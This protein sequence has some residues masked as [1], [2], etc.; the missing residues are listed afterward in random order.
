LSLAQQVKIKGRVV[1]NSNNEP[2]EYVTVYLNSTTFG[3]VTNQS[4]EFNISAPP[5]EYEIV[6]SYLGYTPIIHQVKAEGELPPFLFKLSASEELLNE[7]K[8]EAKR[9]ISWYQNLKVFKDSFL[10]TSKNAQRCKLLNPEVLIIDFDPATGVLKVKARDLLKIENPELGYRINYLL[11]DYKYS[12][13]EHYLAYSGYPNFEEM[14]AGRAKMKKYERKRLKAYNGS[15]MHFVRSLRA[16]KLE[17]EGF[18]LRRL[19]RKP[20][21]NRPGEEEIRRAREIIQA[22]GSDFILKED[23]PLAIT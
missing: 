15:V 9:D 3:A 18:V 22:K 16:Q 17:E 10:G 5:G 1:D 7:V 20:N 6:V 21:P 14:Q 11:A 23:D 13:F 12:M 4:G 2:L 8:V 19:V